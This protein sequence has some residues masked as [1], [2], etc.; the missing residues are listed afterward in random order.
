MHY[1][2]VAREGSPACGAVRGRDTTGETTL[3]KK[4]VT[5]EKCIQLLPKEIP[6]WG[7]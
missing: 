1:A 4:R 6:P 3:N 5:R 2:D 7:L